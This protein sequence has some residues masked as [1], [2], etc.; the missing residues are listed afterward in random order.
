M[1]I[2]RQRWGRKS[3]LGAEKSTLVRRDC[4]IIGC[5]LFS[6]VVIVTIEFPRRKLGN[7]LLFVDSSIRAAVA[8]TQ[9]LCG[10]FVLCRALAAFPSFQQS[11]HAHADIRLILEL[12]EGGFLSAG[13]FPKR[14]PCLRRLNS[15]L[16]VHSDLSNPSDQSLVLSWAIIS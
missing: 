16:L 12:R 10:H 13:K 8:G 14:K 7:G 2:G 11:A 4:C 1:K 9:V 3:L 6:R 15:I 5:Y